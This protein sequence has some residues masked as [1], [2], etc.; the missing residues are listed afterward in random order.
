MSQVKVTPETLD[1]AAEHLGRIQTDLKS[2]AQ[3]PDSDL[4]ALGGEQAF[5]AFAH[6]TDRWKY[7]GSQIDAS[8][9]KLAK[10]LSDT[11]ERY[12]QAEAAAHHAAASAPGRVGV[13]Q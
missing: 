10:T 11:A 3:L 6:F 7:A 8:A 9:A 4:E 12:R 1:A 13:Q 5:A 2:L